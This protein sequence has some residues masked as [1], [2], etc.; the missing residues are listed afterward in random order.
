MSSKKRN[1]QTK[2]LD[3]ITPD[4]AVSVLR[5]LWMTCPDVRVKIEAGIKG[6]LKSVDYSEVA[7]DVESS[8][9]WVHARY[10]V[11]ISGK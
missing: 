11:W 8:L 3:Q 7:S 4:Q 6:L 9:D 2:I 5:N 10:Y 1:Q